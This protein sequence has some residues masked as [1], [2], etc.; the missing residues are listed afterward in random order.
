[1]N[2]HFDVINFVHIV[3][4]VDHHV[5]TDTEGGRIS[6]FRQ[7]TLMS[8]FDWHNAITANPFDGTPTD[9]ESLC[10]KASAII[11]KDVVGV[12]ADQY[13][14]IILY[15]L[16]LYILHVMAMHPETSKSVMKEMDPDLKLKERLLKKVDR[17]VL[18]HARWRGA[19][20]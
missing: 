10:Q 7:S 13:R 6:Q 4:F 12:K 11:E 15:A 19:N 8:A 20:E 5:L 18:M 1:M 2:L 14:L 16:S 3:R 9:F 17:V